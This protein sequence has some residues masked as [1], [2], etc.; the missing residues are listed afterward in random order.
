MNKIMN[1]LYLSKYSIGISI[2]VFIITT[3]AS[4]YLI[5]MYKGDTDED[6]KDKLDWKTLL[7]SVI[8]GVLFI[9][10]TL[11]SYKYIMKDDCDI[12]TEPF[13][14]KLNIV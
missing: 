4:Y 8:V 13:C 9:F 12:L 1:I 6:E 11:A 3:F 5:N 10:I 7:Y 14:S 2:F